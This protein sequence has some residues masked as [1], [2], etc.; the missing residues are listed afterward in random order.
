M[1][2]TPGY[3]EWQLKYTTK[4]RILREAFSKMSDEKLKVVEEE[5]INGIKYEILNPNESDED[6]AYAYLVLFEA[7][8]TPK[9]MKFT[10]G[11]K[12][13]RR[14]YTTSYLKPNL[15]FLSLSAEEFMAAK[16]EVQN[17]MAYEFLNPDE[18]CGSFR[19]IYEFLLRIEEVRDK[20]EMDSRL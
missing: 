4:G 12:E 5:L 1:K 6:F 17:G 16:E 19:C 11:F 20:N 7:R 15:N 3:L 2:R 14:K 9:H 18:S 8:K 10:P 13:W